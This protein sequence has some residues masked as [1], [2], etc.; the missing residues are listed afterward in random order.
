[1]GER[2]PLVKS[3]I[4]GDEIYGEILWIL[5]MKLEEHYCLF[6]KETG[7]SFSSFC[8]NLDDFWR[9]RVLGMTD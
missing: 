6:L 7:V 8:S 3:H 5:G 4:P 9:M 2:N 1:M